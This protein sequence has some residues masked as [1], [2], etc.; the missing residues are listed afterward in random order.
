MLP[1]APMRV[2]AQEALA[3]GDEAGNL[4]KCIGREVMELEAINVEKSTEKIMGRQRKA[5]EEKCEENHRP[6]RFRSRDYLLTWELDF[7]VAE[8]AVLVQ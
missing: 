4:K 5:T 2:D 8:V 7:G 1:K 3:K 6:S